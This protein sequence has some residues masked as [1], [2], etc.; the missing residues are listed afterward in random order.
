M[1]MEVYAFGH[2]CVG[3]WKRGPMGEV[4]GF[5]LAEVE[6]LARWHGFEMGPREWALLQVFERELLESIERERKKPPK[7][8]EP[9]GSSR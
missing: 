8:E 2:V 1:A 5:D 3:R 6:Q 9:K 4:L 7:V